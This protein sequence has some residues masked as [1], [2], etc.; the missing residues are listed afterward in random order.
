MEKLCVERDQHP[1]FAKKALPVMVPSEKPLFRA[2]SN[3]A[4]ITHTIC[5]YY[6]YTIVGNGLSVRMKLQFLHLCEAWGESSQEAKM[7]LEAGKCKGKR[8]PTERRKPQH[9]SCISSKPPTSMMLRVQSPAQE[10]G[11]PRRGV[12]RGLEGLWTLCCP[13]PQS[14]PA[15][16]GR[17]VRAPVASGAIALTF[18]A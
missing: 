12:W 1:M 13:T 10:S 11:G 7:G 8:K 3:N 6:T 5:T 15:D 4:L 17:C 18:R 2:L 16:P 9:V 14:E